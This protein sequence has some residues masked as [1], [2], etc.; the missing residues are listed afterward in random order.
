MPFFSSQSNLLKKKLDS[1]EHDAAMTE[2]E[3]IA[4]VKQKKEEGEIKNNARD[5]QNLERREKHN[6]EE[7][8]RREH[9][10]MRID[11]EERI[12]REKMEHA[13]AEADVGSKAKEALKYSHQIDEL[14][15]KKRHHGAEIDRLEEQN[16]H[17]N[18]QIE[19][20]E[21]PRD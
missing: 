3:R 9:E 5:L 6:D 2:R 21:I 16:R 11:G 4:Y 19:T 15:I 14:D 7:I 1:L 12:I 18:N 13:I 17:I 10:M 8:V 20:L